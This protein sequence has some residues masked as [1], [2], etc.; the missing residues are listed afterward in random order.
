[1]PPQVRI[2]ELSMVERSKIE[3]FK[4][5]VDVAVAYSKG[6]IINHMHYEVQQYNNKKITK[7]A[8]QYLTDAQHKNSLSNQR[9]VLFILDT[10]VVMHH[11]CT[12]IAA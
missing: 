4:K 6:L 12:T 2:T 9:R 3:Q 5:I 11:H 10:T 7:H 1:M 8:K